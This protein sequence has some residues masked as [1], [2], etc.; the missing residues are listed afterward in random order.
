MDFMQVSGALKTVWFVREAFQ[1]PPALASNALFVTLS[2]RDTRMYR[3]A[4]LDY[5]VPCVPYSR[6]FDRLSILLRGFDDIRC[7]NCPQSAYFPTCREKEKI[8]H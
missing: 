6:Q 1:E 2:A 7:L 5:I 3:Q 4:N 8:D